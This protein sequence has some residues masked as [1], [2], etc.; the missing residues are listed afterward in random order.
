MVHFLQMSKLNIFPCSLNVGINLFN[1]I[2]FFGQVDLHLGVGPPGDLDD[3]VEDIRLTSF[4]PRKVYRKKLSIFVLNIISA[5]LMLLVKLKVKMSVM[6]K[7]NIEFFIFVFK[8]FIRRTFIDPKCD[9]LLN[10]IRMLYICA[11]SWIII[12]VLYNISTFPNLCDVGRKRL[13]NKTS[14]ICFAEVK[15]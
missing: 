11:W 8:L 5:L 15:H 3:H 2:E 13:K 9:P 6:N 4:R 1:R 10:L 12:H 14:V 7:I